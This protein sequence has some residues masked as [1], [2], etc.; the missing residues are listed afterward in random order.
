MQCPIPLRLNS[1]PKVEKNAQ[2]YAAL[3]SGDVTLDWVGRFYTVVCSSTQRRVLPARS[4]CVHISISM[5]PIDRSV[6]IAIFLDYYCGIPMSAPA[7]HHLRLAAELCGDGTERVR[8]KYG[9]Q[10]RVSEEAR[11]HLAPIYIL[12]GD[13]KDPTRK[14][15]VGPRTSSRCKGIRAG[16]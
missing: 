8:R 11:L 14:N 16:R 12:L 3:C 7:S 2:P 15:L 13:A 10:R 6:P 4:R 9:L 1:M 5:L